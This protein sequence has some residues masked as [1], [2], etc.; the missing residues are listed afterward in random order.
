MNDAAAK[1]IMLG[2]SA[3]GKT[4]LVIQ[5]HRATFN[6][7]VEPTVGTAYVT[8]VMKT[9]SGSISLHV[10]DTAG[11]ER[12]KSVI[13]MYV[14]GCAAAVI[15][16]AADS[17]ESFTSLESWYRIVQDHVPTVRHIYVVVNKIDKPGQFEF[18]TVSEWA[19]GHN[20]KFFRTCAM[21]GET[22][23]PFFQEVAEDLAACST[24]A[25]SASAL[26]IDPANTRTGCC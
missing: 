11:Q 15:V 17:F 16:C 20:A 26:V 24:F 19:R 22:V 4:S 6:P 1:V 7:N 12:F 3:V 21:H 25:E 8:K 5:L 9:Q 14:R 13:P 18:G 23:L 2:D 10:W